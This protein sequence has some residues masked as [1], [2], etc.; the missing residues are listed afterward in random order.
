MVMPCS[1]GREDVTLVDAIE[2]RVFASYQ[3]EKLDEAKLEELRTG[4]KSSGKVLECKLTP[5]IRQ[6]TTCK[7]REEFEA[8]ATKYMEDS[9]QKSTPS[10]IRTWGHK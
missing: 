4:K 5:S 2:R 10:M 7:N 9:P 1:Y 8:F 3:E 6:K